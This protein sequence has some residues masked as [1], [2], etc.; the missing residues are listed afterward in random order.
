ML[1]R[2]SGKVYWYFDSEQNE[3]PIIVTDSI[4]LETYVK[5][6]HVNK[7]VWTPIKTWK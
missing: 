5:G 7:S 4:V 2:L 3:I 6:H 1:W